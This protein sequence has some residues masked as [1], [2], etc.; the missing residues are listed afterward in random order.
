MKRLLLTTALLAAWSAPALAQSSPG[1]YQGFVPTTAQW[2]SYFAGKQ[3]VI[4]YPTLNKNG[5]IMNGPLRFG[6]ALPALSACGTGP[7]V[8]GNSQ[9]GTVTMGTGSPTGCV[10]TFAVPFAADPVCQVTW[11]ANLAAMGYTHTASALTLTQTATS[12]NKVDYNCA[13]TQ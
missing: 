1:F 7:S 9:Y 6:G 12:S 5:D 13:G 3:D 4:G 8:V 10:I 11:Q 2:N